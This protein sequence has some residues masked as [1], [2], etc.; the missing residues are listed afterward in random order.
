MTN[1][2]RPKEIN[3]F[4]FKIHLLSLIEYDPGTLRLWLREFISKARE[5]LSSTMF[6]SPLKYWMSKENCA[7]PSSAKNSFCFRIERSG[8][9]FGKDCK[10]VILKEMLQTFYI[11]INRKQLRGVKGETKP[12]QTVDDDTPSMPGEQDDFKERYAL[13]TSNLD[14]MIC[15]KLSTD[16]TTTQKNQKSLITKLMFEYN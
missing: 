2:V 6:A 4:C 12:A 13:K 9:W 7:L 10:F 14:K 3:S 11:R 8:M 5:S 15:T 16:H 1:K